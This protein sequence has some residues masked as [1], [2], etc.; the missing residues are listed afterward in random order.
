MRLDKTKLTT[1]IKGTILP[2][3]F[4]EKYELK[5]GKLNNLTGIES[6]RVKFEKN[7]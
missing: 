3:L 1:K 6:E 7:S 5:L 4:N 2:N